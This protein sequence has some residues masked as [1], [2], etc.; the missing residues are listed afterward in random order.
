MLPIFCDDIKP[1]FQQQTMSYF[2]QSVLYNNASK[3]GSIVNARSK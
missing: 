3:K 2:N 1:K